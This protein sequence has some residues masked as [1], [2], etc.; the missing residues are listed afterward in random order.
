MAIIWGLGVLV[1]ITRHNVRTLEKPSLMQHSPDVRWKTCAV[2]D[3]FQKSAPVH[4][5]SSENVC[6]A[7]VTP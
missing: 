2:F 6:K 5:D 1:H 7:L 4:A 3:L